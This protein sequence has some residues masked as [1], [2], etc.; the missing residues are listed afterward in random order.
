MGGGRA[1][2]DAR[3]SGPLSH[4]TMKKLLDMWEAASAHTGR[5]WAIVPHGTS[6]MPGLS[7]TAAAA[8]AGADVGSSESRISH[9]TSAALTSHCSVACSSCAASAS[10]AAAAA[11]ASRGAS[12]PKSAHSSATA[13]PAPPKISK[14]AGCA[15]E[16]RSAMRARCAREG[17]SAMRARC[18]R[19]GRS[20][21]PR[22]EQGVPIYVPQPA[23]G[24]VPR[25]SR[26][27]NKRRAVTA[28][29]C[30]RAAWSR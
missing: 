13:K 30:Q 17:R 6:P 8:G 1:A 26:S 27:R 15:R 21:M 3:P 12:A 14:A 22:C 9:S 18:A 11:A 20:A 23:P 24:G 28:T 25:V 19:E 16:G 29:C 2:F 10:A 5:D 7:S 4:L